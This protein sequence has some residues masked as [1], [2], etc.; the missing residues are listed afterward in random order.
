MVTWGV[1]GTHTDEQG[2]EPATATEESGVAMLLGQLQDRKEAVGKPIPRATD[3]EYTGRTARL[4]L[5]GTD[6]MVTGLDC[7]AQYSLTTAAELPEGKFL[8]SATVETNGDGDPLGTERSRVHVRF[9]GPA[10]LTFTDGEILLSLWESQRVTVGIGERLSVGPARIRIPASVEGL[11]TG[12][13]NLSSAHHTMAPSRSHPGQR[14]HPPLL[15]TGASLSIPDE[16]ESPDTGIE[17][18]LP[19]SVAALFVAAPLAYYLGADVSAGDRDCP[20]LTA[21]GT[22]VRREFDPLPSLQDEVANV[23]RRVFYLDCL[24]RRMDPEQDPKLLDRCSLSPPD[25]RALSPAGRLARYL[26][27]PTEAVA[28]AVPEWHLSTHTQPSLARAR[29]LPFLLD[30]LSLIYLSDG[31]ELERRDLLDSTLSDSFQTRGVSEATTMVEPTGGTGRVHGW[32][33]PGT[34]IDA[35]KTMPTAYENRY[36]YSKSDTDRLQLSVV[37]NEMEMTEEHRAVSEIYRAADLPMNVTVSDGLTTGELADVFE[38]DNDFVHFIG[39]CEDDG[40]ACPD[41]TLSMASLAESRTRTF[42]LNACGSYEEGLELIEQGAVAGAVT[43][44]DVLDRHAAMVG[45]AF[46]RLLSN[47]FSIQRALQLARRRIMMGKDY[48]VVGDGT[49]ALLPGPTAP[50]VVRV[51]AGEGQYHL[52][53]EVLTPTGAGESY[54]LPFEGRTVLNGTETSFSVDPETLVETLRATSLPAVFEGEFHWSGD[55]AARL[56]ASF[57]AQ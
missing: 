17:L 30:P 16:V 5:P 8:L 55:L 40:L 23:L 19:D 14:G 9:G 52:T 56:D 27:T 26:E 6:P 2:V 51:T 25:V 3:S 36:R 49:Y 38:S 15:T 39:H 18:R 1:A 35:F 50:I 31:V 13:S 20:V 44:T 57:S 22:D 37:L 46:A 47:G 21:A 41:G 28:A 4:R 34:P 33:A 45:T 24:V 53:C 32:L 12:L 48:A 29:C 42:F 11:A 10:S 54:Q 43:F 7:D